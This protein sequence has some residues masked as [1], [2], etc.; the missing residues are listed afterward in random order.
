MRTRRRCLDGCTEFF[1]FRNARMGCSQIGQ[2]IGCR[3]G[4]AEQPLVASF[5]RID[6]VLTEAT[7]NQSDRVERP[8]FGRMALGDHERRHVPAD[9]RQATNKTQSSDGGVVMHA[10]PAADGRMIT[11][12]DMAR[13]HDLI[14]QRDAIAKDTVMCDMRTDHQQAV[15]SDHS[16]ATTI[17]GPSVNSDMFPDLV[18]ITDAQHGVLAVELSIL[19]VTAHCGKRMHHIAFAQCR[20]CLDVY[21]LHE[22][23]AVADFDTRTHKAV[24]ADLDILSDSSRGIDHRR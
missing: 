20:I 23:R 18:S 12:L 6:G 24:R 21:V 16:L 19:G 8:H 3:S 14:G 5:Q 2:L 10:C 17:G 7:A 9:P 15:G 4:I 11:N 22:N 1:D 13:K